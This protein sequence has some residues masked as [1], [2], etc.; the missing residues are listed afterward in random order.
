MEGAL[1]FFINVISCQ[2]SLRWLWQN[3]DSA[4][5]EAA[6]Y[7]VVKHHNLL[8]TVI[9]EGLEDTVLETSHIFQL[10]LTSFIWSR[11]TQ[12]TEKIYLCPLLLFSS[13]EDRASRRNYAFLMFQV[14]C[15]LSPVIMMVAALASLLSA[16]LLPLFTLPVF[17]LTFPRPAR[18]WPGGGEYS[19][20][21]KKEFKNK[22][23][24]EISV[25]N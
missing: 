17:F 4:L 23:R 11:M 9:P 3:P 15:I 20:K 18:F 1:N 19:A 2:R 5:T 6:V 16:P 21:L 7:H 12:F 22:N 10:A 14:S 8:N 13:I 25:I 24:M